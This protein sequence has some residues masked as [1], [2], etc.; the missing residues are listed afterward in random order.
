M[1]DDAFT[2]RILVFSPC[3]C[4]VCA[5]GARWFMCPFSGD[6]KVASYDCIPVEEGYYKPHPQAIRD[7]AAAHPGMDLVY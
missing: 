3:K 1:N 2:A 4:D 6:R 5:S 7:V